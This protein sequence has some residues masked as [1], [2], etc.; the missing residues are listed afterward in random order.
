MRSLILIFLCCFSLQLHSQNQQLA[1]QYFRNGEYDKAAAIYKKLF[2]KHPYNLN[3]LNY[4][5]DSY[6]QLEQFNEADLLLKK[7]LQ[8]FPSQVQLNIEI[9]YNY[10]LQHETEKAIPYYNKAINEIKNTPSLGYAIGRTF[11]NNHLLDYALKAYQIAT[12]ANPKANYYFQIAAIYGEKTDIENMFN[13]YLKLLEKNEV[14]IPSVKNHIQNF[15]TDDSE[16]ENNKLLKK[17]LFKQLQ[18]NPLSSWNQLLSW[19]Y[20]QEKNYQRAFIQEKALHKRALINLKE[21]E[22]LGEI[23]FNNQAFDV[24]KNCFHYV[25]ENTQDKVSTLNSKLYLLEINLKTTNRV[26]EIEKEF[27]ELFLLYGK[28]TETIALQIAYADFLVF[29]KND[30][31]AAISTLKKSLKLP[32]NKFQEGRIKLKLADVLVYHNKFNSAL[33]YYTQ[34]QNNLKNHEIAQNARFK[35][36]QTSYFKGDFDW[37]QSQLKVLK[38]ATSQ[39]IANDA[40]DLNLLITDNSVKDSLRIALKKYATADL[41]ALQHKKK[42]AIDTLQIILTMFKGHP[43]EDEALFKQAQL[44]EEENLFQKAIANYLKIIQLNKDDILADDAYYSLAEL[45]LTKLNNE[46]KAKEYYQKIIFE[47]PSSIFLVDARK[48]YRKLRGDL[49]N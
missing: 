26:D 35:I 48:K 11:Q 5:V 42:A 30:P 32:V 16:N 29:Q 36:A 23:A 2:E 20:I 12:A 17:L 45:Y 37:A 49:I 25:L 19:L 18:N 21:I 14:Y 44:F 27:Q 46:K 39:L 13:T 10:Q 9:G 4:L 22:T 3:Y 33:I 1:Y 38:N 40:L 8:Q 41:L 34:I 47:Y 24:A 6:Q 31:D 7:Q 28:N 43:I 15:I